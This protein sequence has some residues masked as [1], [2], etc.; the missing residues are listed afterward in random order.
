MTLKHLIGLL[1]LSLAVS[2]CQHSPT[3]PESKP[4][5]PSDTR[6][7]GPN[8]LLKRQWQ[9]EGKFA[10]SARQYQ[11]SGSFDWQNRGDDYRIRFFGPMG[12]GSAWLSKSGKRVTFESEKDGLKEAA[13][14]E[15]LMTKALGWAIP[16]SELQHW[17]K[18][19]AAPG[20]PVQQQLLDDQGQLRQLQ[21]Q[22]WQIDYSGYQNQNGWPLPGK[23]VATRDQVKVT[24]VIKH[25]QLTAPGE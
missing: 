11:E 2:A 25:W 7:Q 14:A 5:P 9:A 23:L 21:Q 17:I 16:I 19:I 24:L 8:L 4:A 6:P 10:V 22:G 15:Q 1:S 3:T 12:F 18:G 20:A 13:S